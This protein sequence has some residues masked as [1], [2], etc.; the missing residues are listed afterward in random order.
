ML[1]RGELP[2]MTR[3][4]EAGEKRVRLEWLRLELRMELDRHIPRMGWQLDDLN[5]LAIERSADDLETV[6][7]QCLFIQA[8]EFVPVSMTFVDYRLSVELMRSRSRLELARIRS[9]AHGAA[10]IVYPEQIAQLVDDLLRRVGR[11]LG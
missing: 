8:I 3:L 7:R 9:E 6:I 2:R 11:T 10:K 4:N 1:P 5:E